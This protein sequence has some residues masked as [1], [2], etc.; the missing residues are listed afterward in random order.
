M[1][2]GIIDY[3]KPHWDEGM[4]SRMASRIIS[5]LQKRNDSL[6][7]IIANCENAK[8]ARDLKR[9][10]KEIALQEKSISKLQNTIK[11]LRGDA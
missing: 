9:A 7:E 5:I 6:S 8:L 11:Q 3:I 4:K 10:N 1:E 2:D